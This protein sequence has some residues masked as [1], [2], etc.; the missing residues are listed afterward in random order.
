MRRDT[1]GSVVNQAKNGRPR[2]QLGK[3]A[4]IAAFLLSGCGGSEPERENAANP[5]GIAANRAPLSALIGGVKFAAVSADE[6]RAAEIGRDVL[7]AGGNAT[8]AAVAMYFAMAV[9]LPSAASL[10]ASGVCVVHDSR[11]KVGEA[12]AFGPVSAP[13]G[14]RGV[15]IAVPTGGVRALT[16]MHARHGELRWEAAVA[17]AERLARLGVPVS[18]ALSRDLQAGA[19][20]LGADGE[21]RR[22]FGRGTG[23]AVTEGDILIQTDLAATLGSIRQRGGADF[24]QGSL[25]RLMSEQVAQLGGSMPLE[26]I[27]STVPQAGPPTSE[28]YGGFRVYVAPAP[29]AGA[30]A[31]AGWNGQPGPGGTTPSDS[32]GIAGFAAI[33]QKGG[34]AACSTSMGEL[35]GARIVVPGTGVLL[36]TPTP[37]STAISPLVVGNPGNGEVLFAGAGGGSPSAPFALGVIARGTVEHKQYV[38]AALQARRGQGGYV[39]AIAC[40]DGIRSGGASCNSAADPAGTGLALLATTR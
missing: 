25:A 34:A 17:P 13:G 28:R 37:N 21:A 4:L 33:D 14:I 12:F 10:G 11:T 30:L 40:P 7:Q 9:T 36:A 35:F 26:S 39:N 32:N 29:M 31:L 24:F 22:I 15:Q 8:D 38:S 6:S 5:S 16:L 20:A 2:R 18:R 27:R 23:T 19:V 1:G 3:L